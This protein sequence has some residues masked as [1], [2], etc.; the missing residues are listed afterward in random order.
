MASGM[1]FGHDPERVAK[2]LRLL[3]VVNKKLGQLVRN[4]LK[5]Y[6]K[7]NTNGHF[8]INF[9]LRRNWSMCENTS[10]NIV[11]HMPFCAISVT[12]APVTTAI[13]SV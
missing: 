3:N 13:S 10:V 4:L 1:L 11:F 2:F 6:E 5:F 7:Y 8:P 9:G 12:G